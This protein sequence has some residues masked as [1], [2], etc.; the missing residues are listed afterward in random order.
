MKFAQAFP[1]LVQDALAKA[2]A[3]QLQDWLVAR[4]DHPVVSLGLPRPLYGLGPAFG[5]ERQL[6]VYEKY[7][8]Q[9]FSEGVPDSA[10][11]SNSTW[12]EYAR[13]ETHECLPCVQT[14]WVFL[15]DVADTASW[16]RPS[17]YVLD[18]CNLNQ[19]YELERRLRAQG[20]TLPLGSCLMLNTDALRQR[21]G[22][23]RH[24][25]VLMGEHVRLASTAWYTGRGTRN[26]ARLLSFWTN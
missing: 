10:R 6:V 25:P 8:L 16:L 7:P 21:G 17:I 2:A 1:H 14:P 13:W 5:P 12:V 3:P 18:T 24:A 20:Q 15:T 4:P 19:L 23:E 11:A 9:C 22:A 26:K